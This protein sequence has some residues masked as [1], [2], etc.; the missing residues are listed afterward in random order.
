[1][2]GGSAERAHEADS[3]LN[4]SVEWLQR[5]QRYYSPAR[6]TR[7]YLA[8][9][10]AQSAEALDT[11]ACSPRIHCV[12]RRDREHPPVCDVVTSSK[13][14]KPSVMSNRVKQHSTRG[15]RCARQNSGG[16]LEHFQTSNPEPSKAQQTSIKKFCTTRP[17]LALAGATL[18]P[19][20]QLAPKG[21]PCAPPL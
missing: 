21:S 7:A 10:N 5:E 15:P 20:H 14:E 3:S 11:N 6:A 1:M 8:A 19:P 13:T 17:V 4:D 16:L 2:P 9:C 18:Q 12:R